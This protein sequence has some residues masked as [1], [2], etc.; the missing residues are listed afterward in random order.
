MWLAG[1]A[2]G[3]AVGLGA[4]WVLALSF[5]IVPADVCTAVEATAAV[6]TIGSTLLVDLDAWIIRAQDLLTLELPASAGT[7]EGLGGLLDRAKN[8]AEAGVVGA[9]HALTAPLTDLLD[10]ARS[11]L[12]AVREAVKAADNLLEALED[13]C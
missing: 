13:R 3:L 4:G 10:L 11:L 12:S 9:V 8:V 7:R 1:L 5:N 2:G 6:T